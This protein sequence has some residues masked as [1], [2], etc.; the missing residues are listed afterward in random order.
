[1][2]KIHSSCSEYNPVRFCPSLC[3]SWTNF[4]RYVTEF[5]IHWDNLLV[6]FYNFWIFISRKW[7]KLS[8]WGLIS[9]S[10]LREWSNFVG[11]ITETPPLHV[12]DMLKPLHRNSS[13]LEQRMSKI[14]VASG[15]INISALNNV[16]SQTDAT[17]GILLIISISSTCF[18]R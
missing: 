11:K 16:N 2:R 12:F 18:G 8:D 10:I 13:Y 15:H 6:T 4:T 17:I 9:S 1:M 5:L 14:T 7:L 3:S